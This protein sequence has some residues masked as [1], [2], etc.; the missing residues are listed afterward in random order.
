MGEGE[1]CEGQPEVFAQG[2]GDALFAEVGE[3]VEGGVV[4]GGR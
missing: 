3:L 1:C 4:L 2:R